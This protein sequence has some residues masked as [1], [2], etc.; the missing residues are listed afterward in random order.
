MVDQSNL[1]DHAFEAQQQDKIRAKCAPFLA[2][3]RKEGI[4]WD[5]LEYPS[6]FENG[7]VG[8]KVRAP[9]K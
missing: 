3:C 2:W 1:P 4:V 7:L 6:F 5:K 9:I 8:V